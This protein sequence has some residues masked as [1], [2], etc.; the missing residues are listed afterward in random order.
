M[1][2]KDYTRRR[3]KNLPKF[4]RFLIFRGNKGID[5]VVIAVRTSAGEEIEDYLNEWSDDVNWFLPLL[6]FEFFTKFHN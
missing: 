3:L 4:N 2:K 5:I 1:M 6:V